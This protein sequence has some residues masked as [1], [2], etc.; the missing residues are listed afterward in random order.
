MKRLV[1][2]VGVL[3]S[4]GP[5]V[6]VDEGGSGESFGDDSGSANDVSIAAVEALAKLVVDGESAAPALVALADAGNDLPWFF[7]QMT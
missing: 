2:A 6:D 4:C 3:A 7:R 1:V 5:K